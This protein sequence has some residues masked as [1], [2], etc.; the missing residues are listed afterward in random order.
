MRR[1]SLT[2]KTRDHAENIRLRP[3]LLRLS[4]GEGCSATSL[5]SLLAEV[6]REH[7]REGVVTKLRDVAL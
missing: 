2:I 1:T 3:D 5:A 6:E 7:V 4:D